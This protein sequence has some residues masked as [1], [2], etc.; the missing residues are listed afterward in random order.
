M[1]P[2]PESVHALGYGGYAWL[3]SQRVCVLMAS[4]SGGCMESFTKPVLMYLTGESSSGKIVSEAVEG[5]VPDTVTR[6]V[7]NFDGGK[8]QEANIDRNAFKIDLQPGDAV[9]GETVTLS[10]GTTFFY[11]DPLTGPRGPASN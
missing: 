7:I 6:L 8:I 11:P 4:G 9:T 1:R 5:V 2:S 3:D 10:D